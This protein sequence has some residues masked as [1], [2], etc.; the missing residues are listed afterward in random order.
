MQQ[1]PRALSLQQKDVLLT[2]FGGALFT[3]DTPVHGHKVP[4][5]RP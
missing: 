2:I 3:F 5:T 1:P 4:F